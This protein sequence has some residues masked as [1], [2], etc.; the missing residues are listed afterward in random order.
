MNHPL[1][2]IKVLV[3]TTVPE[4]VRAFL[5]PQLADPRDKGCEVHIATGK[6]STLPELEGVCLVSV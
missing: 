1:K 3:V 4:T 2:S 6:G 5:V